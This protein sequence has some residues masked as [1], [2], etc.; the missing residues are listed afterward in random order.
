[1]KLR[2]VTISETEK[3]SQ[4]PDM[5]EKLRQ[6]MMAADDGNKITKQDKR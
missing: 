2:K 3:V 4:E 5:S 1:M 6:I